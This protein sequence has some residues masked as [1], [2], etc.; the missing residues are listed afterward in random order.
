MNYRG[1][2]TNSSGFTILELLISMSVFAVVL[3]VIAVGVLRFTDDYYKGVTSSKTQATARAIMSEVS[4]SIEFSK[5]VTP[6]PPGASGIGG[7]CVDN[8]LYSYKVG[9]EVIDNS[10]IG[11]QHQ[12]FHDLV[13]SN[14]GTCTGSTTPTLPATLPAGSRELLGQHMRL[15]AFSI[16]STGKVF[17]I[18]VRV[19]YGEDPL[20]NPPVSGGTNWAT[21]SCVSGMGSQFCAVSDLTTTVEQRLL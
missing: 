5:T 21:E 8:L 6:I 10:P 2:R 9:Q 11:S 12:W 18:R 7:L 16:T 17:T 14:P 4:Q 20:L 15:G 1:H 13:V 3:L 19:I